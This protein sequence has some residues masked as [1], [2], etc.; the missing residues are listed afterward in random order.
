MDFPLNLIYLAS[1]LKQSPVGVSAVPLD[2]TF[3]YLSGKS[4]AASLSRAQ[5]L[6]VERAWLEKG[7]FD[8]V[9][10]GGLCDNFHLSV[11]LAE[12]VKMRFSVPVVM[13]GPHATFVAKEL[14]AA[15]PFM[16]FVISNDGSYP[17]SKLCE[18]LRAESFGKVP[19]L[20]YRSRETG[21]IIQN[22]RTE[23]VQS[24]MNI[25]P[26]YDLLP[27]A[28][29]LKINPESSIPVLAGSGCPFQCTYCSTSLMWDRRY[30]VLSAEAIRDQILS[31]KRRFPG[32]RFSLVHDNLLFSKDFAGRLC[33]ELR[34]TGAKWGCSSRLEHVAGDNS[35]MKN[36]A[37]SG[38]EVIFVGIETGAPRMQRLTGKNID[39]S[40]VVPF[41]QDLVRHG[42]SAVF[43][44]IVGFPEET[45]ADR[46]KTLRLAFYLRV[47]Q[48]ERVNI[49]HL[50]PLPG[51]A[52][53]AKNPVYP[54]KAA[55]Y[56][57]PQLAADKKTRELVFANPYI[58]RSFWS[59]ADRPGNTGLPPAA[60]E[61][62]HTYGVEHY[63][64]FNYLFSRAGVRP[65]ALF[66]ILGKKGPERGIVK[67]IS[68]LAGPPH[69]RV[70]SE[71]FRYESRLMKMVENRGTLPP[72]GAR[73]RYDEG[74]KYSLSSKV[75]LFKSPLPL[76]SYLEPE[77]PGSPS[78][79]AARTTFLCLID[80][81]KKIDAY[82]I[83]EEL[84]RA[85]GKMSGKGA[86]PRDL[87]PSV[88]GAEARS[89]V[90]QSL[91]KIFEMGVLSDV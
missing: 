36:L 73:R 79:R 56:R 52:V 82:E 31:L 77:P 42:L 39:I 28:E 68:A 16:D 38:C 34:K 41:A 55:S 45:D 57:P 70:F 6:Y 58:F 64:S 46:D 71:L 21:G 26:D 89:I 11:R 35:L 88:R 7:P 81:G 8:L 54:L 91:K 48:A 78:A 83:H 90:R 66:G 20:T 18:A 12:F 30:K 80:I 47:L 5:E 33:K 62:L 53:A 87:V 59:F 63:R 4:K 14:L 72:S 60:T 76:P 13:G 43:S 27:L 17:L 25:R 15:F 74:S 2:L 86:R 29:Y 1:G 22:P 10:I 49:N 85:L 40:R 24:I 9:G 3:E 84:F 50:F 75:G 67:K 65:G 37:A 32:A 44:F 61:A 69:G 51:T 23:G 19:A